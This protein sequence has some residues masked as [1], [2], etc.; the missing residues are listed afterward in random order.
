MNRRYSGL[1][2][3][4][5]FVA[6]LRSAVQ[7]ECGTAMSLCTAAP[8]FL[9]LEKR[10]KTIDIRGRSGANVKDMIL[11]INEIGNRRPD[12][13]IF[14]VG[15][16]DLCSCSVDCDAKQIAQNLVSLGNLLTIGYGIRT[17]VFCSVI[18][19]KKCR[20]ISHCVFV[21]RAKVFNKKLFDL[22]GENPQLKF[23]SHSGFWRD[24]DTGGP[25]P[26]GQWSQD[27]IH[28]GPQVA[29]HGFW[30]YQRNIRRCLLESIAELRKCD[31]QIEKSD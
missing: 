1:I 12:V 10:F 11:F 31:E 23:Y 26:V 20:G 8:V 30:K 21:E 7:L 5:S 25:M 22:C 9:K 3:G 24:N 4:H 14:D 27:G 6:R 16:N 2:L 29:S 17:V 15:S 18:F 19:R 28:P 13:V